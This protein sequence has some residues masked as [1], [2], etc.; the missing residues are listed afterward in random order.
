MVRRLPSA[1]DGVLSWQNGGF[2]TPARL[3]L[4]GVALAVLLFSRVGAQT[5]FVV[6]S[7]GGNSANLSSSNNWTPNYA[8]PSGSSDASHIAEFN[9]SSFGTALHLQ[10]SDWHA[11]GIQLDAVTANGLNPV[12]AL[13]FDSQGSGNASFI[14]VGSA[15]I[16][17]NA[18]NALTF[19]ISTKVNLGLDASA[20]FA[21]NNGPINIVSA[22]ATFTIKSFTLTLSGAN[23]NS[24][25][26]QA[27][28]D[29]GGGSLVKS[30]TGT[31]T[32][33]GANTYTGTTAIQQGTLSVNS[34]AVNSGAS[35]LG[36]ATSSVLLGNSTS[37]GTLAYTGNGVNFT[38][39]F[40]VGAGGGE[41]DVTTSGQTVTIAT[42]GVSTTGAGSFTL[43][44]AGSTTIAS[45]ITGTGGLAQTGGGTL[46]L[47]NGGNNFSGPVTISAGV[48]TVNSGATLA[49]ATSP[50][51]I[52]GGTLNLN[53]S[54]QTIGSLAGPG[55]TI[56][57]G[58]GHTLTDNQTITSAFA[59]ALAGSGSFVKS[60]AGALVLNGTDTYTGTT[61]VSGGTLQFGK[62]T[63]L[64]NNTPA[65]WTATNLVVNSGATLALNVGGSGEFTPTNVDTLVALGTT[66]GGFKG[67][68]FIGFD[69]T[70]AGGTFTYNS[71]IVNPGGNSLGV[72]KLGTGTLVLGG[73]NTYS[74]DTNVNSGTLKLGAASALSPNTKL[75][76]APGASFDA[77]GFTQTFSDLSGSGSLNVG[78]GV[79]VQPTGASTFTGTLSGSGGF[80]MSGSGTL[81]LGAANSFQGPTVVSSGTVKLGAPGALP[82]NTP[83]TLST[84]A[85][86]DLNG[87]SATLGKLD[88][89]G[90]TIALG[91]ATLTINQTAN[92]V[93][94]GVLTGSGG[95]T[96]S[97]NG[98][99]S[100][101]G[102]QPF[103]G[104]T[105]ISGGELKL[106]GS[107]TG[108]AFSI[109]SGQ[110][111]GNATV[112][113][114]TV[115]AGGTVSPGN[116]PGHITVS[117]DL[118]L[119]GT[120]AMEL[121]A[122]GTRG[123]DYDAF[124][125][126]GAI[127]FGGALNVSFY[128]GY[129]PVNGARFDLFDW[130]NGASGTFSAIVL[131]SLDS[132]LSWD[133]S[134]LYSTG[135]LSVSAAAIPEPTT[136]AALIGLAAFGMVAMRKRQSA[137]AGSL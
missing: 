79:T 70:N 27:I 122:S 105:I 121:A 5:T 137:R 127:A 7:N 25:I 111:S 106:N 124:T 52:S 35:A 59:G 34:I 81:T 129:D 43:G 102:T 48:L 77:S 78:S 61:T 80:T 85:T 108:S 9:L 50:L 10:N 74:G 112:G 94:S 63:A 96:K 55:G 56:N 90:G 11:L 40:T 16:A 88:G 98:Q 53:N 75:N 41:F 62:Q 104:N 135:V 84:G 19:D 103:T 17:N 125:V 31:W 64:Y 26:S 66:N 30:G 13:T 1:H 133:T 118:T 116:S 89:V 126:Q 67:G 60:G 57:L 69:T 92:T 136:C 12:G 23:T 117:G 101:T 68:S 39:G 99:L 100:L 20:S 72:V 32:L 2:R 29:T 119:G 28:S 38:R 51:A 113:S 114:L 93:F 36:N 45:A 37:K 65:S 87:N 73:A 44:G 109:T 130:G 46:T 83:V 6:W 15:G 82:A 76:V 91:G 97:G 47:T 110:L 24:S 18:S 14:Y 54:A 71:N 33:A 22:G 49:S 95:L 3:V 8:F 134:A 131:P 86:L 4:L 115:G 120:T 42:G 21:A 132:G 123:V 128:N 58:S 107:A